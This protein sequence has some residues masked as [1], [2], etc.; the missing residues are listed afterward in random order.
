MMDIFISL[1]RG[2]FGGGIG[3]EVVEKEVLEIS[4]MFNI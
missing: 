3:E 4:A 1:M 2:G